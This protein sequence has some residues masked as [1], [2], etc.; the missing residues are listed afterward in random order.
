MIRRNFPRWA[1]SQ[2]FLEMDAQQLMAVMA[3]DDVEVCI[4][5]ELLEALLRWLDHD[6][7]ARL[8]HLP[9]LLQIVRAAFLSDQARQENSQ[10]LASSAAVPPGLGQGASQL[11]AG[12]LLNSAARPSYG[13]D[14]LLG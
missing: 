2:D 11:P 9:A 4:E 3:S 14:P 6:S 10:A 5:D 1:P 12:N 13:S 7:P 8:E